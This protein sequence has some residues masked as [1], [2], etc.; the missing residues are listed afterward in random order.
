[1]CGISGYIGTNKIST[2][3]IKSTLKL[4]KFRGP[5]KKNTYFGKLTIKIFIFFIQDYQ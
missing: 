4:M 1:M 5:D 2:N 3:R